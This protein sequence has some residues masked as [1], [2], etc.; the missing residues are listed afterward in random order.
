MGRPCCGEGQQP[1]DR[2]RPLV[3][4]LLAAVA[5]A[6]ALGASAS[7][8]GA[9]LTVTSAQ[10]VHRACG[11]PRPGAAACTALRLVS[12]PITAGEVQATADARAAR[13]AAKSPTYLT[14]QSL[15]TA[16]SL[17]AETQFSSTQTIAV[18]DAFDDPTAE[19]D[20]GVYDEMFGLPACT[21]ANGCFR[22]LNEQGLASPLP[23]ENGEWASEISI[24]VQMAHAICQNCH[25]LLVE[26][27]SEEFTDLGA[28]VNT[29]V[30]AG[31]TEVSNSY[32]GPEEP[33]LASIFS[34][35]NTSYYDHAG[36]VITASSGDCGYLNEA[37]FKQLATADFPADSP[38]V[39][40]VGGTTL[41]DR[42]EWNSSVWEEGGSGC[43]QIF[44]APPWQSAV[45]DFSDTG[46]GGERSVADVAAIGNPN[47]G[48]EIYDSTPEASGEP[49][50]WGVWGGT[51]VASPI[52]AAEFALAGGS[53]GVAFPAATLY[54]HLG[55]GKDLY[56]VVSGSNGVCGASISCQAAV[57]YDGPTGVGSPI[58]LGAFST[59]G[60]P[61]NTSP[62]AI[63]GLAEEGQTLTATPG[64]WTDSPTVTSEQWERCGA[65]GGSCS[66]IAG[67]TTQKYALTASDIGSTLRV[68]EVASNAA[69]VSSPAQSALS[70]VVSSNVPKLAGFTPSSGITGSTVTI[71]GTA[72][73]AVTSVKFGALEAHFNVVSATEVEAVVPDGASAGKVSLTT[74]VGSAQSKSKFAPTLSVTAF[75]PHAGGPGTRVTIK[76]VGF[77][78][79][80]TVS[81]GG[82]AAIVDSASAKKLKVTVPE[83]ALSG[84][85]AV[86]NATA[87]AGTV[88]SAASF[89]P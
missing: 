87:P 41:T 57:G 21:S 34:E 79:S 52:V 60:S 51:S 31:A 28:A 86:T 40:A 44:A 45:A 18:I 24:D 4:A 55:D 63:S 9:S 15:H 36:V 82:V 29:A 7:P 43:S 35:L 75:L 84:A 12:A 58:G 89:T 54:S 64:T 73:G 65:S 11:A 77:S 30:K 20:L 72:L 68:Q 26:A 61:A 69:G 74:P 27:N 80:S 23:A 88:F 10:G 33:A 50:G 5:V 37:C 59:A 85:I 38:D 62:P 46:C 19:A 14:P 3:G 47:T 49:G 70:A 22:K 53:H 71:H 76:G 8:A 2:R 66:A 56:D 16:Y 25:V 81:F 32:G 42:T 83:G 1:T 67:A 39:V 48:V 78:A 13:V 6:L 17:P